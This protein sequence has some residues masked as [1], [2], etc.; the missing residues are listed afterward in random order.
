VT[1]LGVTRGNRV[2][3]AERLEIVQRELIAREMKNDVLKST[4]VGDQLSHK[5]TRNE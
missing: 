3:L 5:T 2:N 1:G 4:A